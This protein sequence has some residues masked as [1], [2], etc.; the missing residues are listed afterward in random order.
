MTPE[1]PEQ[2]KKEFSKLDWNRIARLEWTV[3]DW[4]DYYHGIAFAL[5]KIAKR[6]RKPE[7]PVIDFQI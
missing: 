1:I 7:A 6:H 3:E 2:V 5:W 4:T